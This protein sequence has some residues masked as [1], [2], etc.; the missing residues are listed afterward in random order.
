MDS[1]VHQFWQ[2]TILL[3]YLKRLYRPH[4]THT[5]NF[6][7]K[8]KY[9]CHELQHN[10]KT[11][12]DTLNWKCLSLPLPYPSSPHTHSQS[13]DLGR[14]AQVQY[15]V[16]KLIYSRSLLCV[17]KIARALGLSFLQQQRQPFQTVCLIHLC[18]RRWKS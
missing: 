2:L 14:A 8:K 16:K 18:F 7:V 11:I 6:M 13:S 5:C 9:H 17:L 1:R 3:Q 12:Q 10:L 4:A 15:G